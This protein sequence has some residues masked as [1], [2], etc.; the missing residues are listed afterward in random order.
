MVD[1]YDKFCFLAQNVSECLSGNATKA[2]NIA[3]NGGNDIELAFHAWYTDRNYAN[4][5]QLKIVQ[6]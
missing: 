4:T 6:A 2:E 5:L 1:E 3:D